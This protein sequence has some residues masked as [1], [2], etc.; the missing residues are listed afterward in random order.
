MFLADKPLSYRELPLSVAV[1]VFACGAG[2]KEHLSDTPCALRMHPAVTFL[3][4]QESNQ[5]TPEGKTP[6]FP[7]ETH[8]RDGDQGL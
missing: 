8:S 5:R 7:F 4:V 3:L 2:R 6:V 1:S